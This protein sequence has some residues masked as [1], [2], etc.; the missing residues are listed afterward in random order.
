MQNYSFWVS[1]FSWVLLHYCVGSSMPLCRSLCST[2]TCPHNVFSHYWNQNAPV[3]LTFDFRFPGLHFLYCW[4]EGKILK[5]THI[6]VWLLLLDCLFVLFKHCKISRLNIKIPTIQSEQNDSGLLERAT[7]HI[8][9]FQNGAGET[10]YEWWKQTIKKKRYL[11]NLTFL[12]HGK[13]LF[14][15]TAK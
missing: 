7:G 6:L 10:S 12:Y 4:E 15:F 3:F 11:S 14:L 1:A 2:E 8:H 9:A 5:S 13:F